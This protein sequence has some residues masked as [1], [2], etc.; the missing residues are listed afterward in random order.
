[1]TETETNGKALV[2]HW[3]WAAEKGLMNKNTAGGLRAACSQ[4]L[5]VLD[6]PDGVDIKTLDVEGALTRFQNLKMKKFKPAVLGTYKQRFRKAV[7]SYL[8]Y[9]NDPGGWK[10]R[11]L[12]RPS[13]DGA[14][15][16]NGGGA[17]AER[18]AGAE[19][20]D[21]TRPTKFEMPQANMM[22]YPFP[23]REGQIAHLILPRDLKVAEV[24]R[25]TAF[26]ATLAV[27]VEPTAS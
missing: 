20:V 25:L 4:V 10:P 12:D 18:R 2:D 13:N 21:L 3:I 24:K 1:M 22:D 7:A 23:I 17:G 19:R 16:T 14:E 5:G 15:K 6:D 27:D 8:A 11:S 26:M 9:L